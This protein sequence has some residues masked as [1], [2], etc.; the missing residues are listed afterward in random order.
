MT[1][2][3]PLVSEAIRDHSVTISL[4]P[5][6]EGPADDLVVDEIFLTSSQAPMRDVEHVIP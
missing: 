2:P 3:N 5:N 1:S 6:P 4:S